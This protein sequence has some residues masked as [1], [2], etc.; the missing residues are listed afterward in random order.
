MKPSSV[1]KLSKAFVSGQEKSF[2][3]PAAEPAEREFPESF[4]FI[5][6]CGPFYF[7]HTRIICPSC[8]IWSQVLR[9]Y[10]GHAWGL[11]DTK[12]RSLAIWVKGSSINATEASLNSWNR[13]LIRYKIKQCSFNSLDFRNDAIY[14]LKLNFVS[15]SWVHCIVY[16]SQH[17]TLFGNFQFFSNTIDELR[18][19]LSF[20]V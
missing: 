18:Q 1:C 6:N 16:S 5:R 12:Q 11:P 2:I 13:Y 14:F 20:G 3:L 9:H 7:H 17:C 19:Q 4:I 10:Q 15:D 8:M